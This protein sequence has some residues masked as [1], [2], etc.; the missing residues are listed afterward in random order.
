[1]SVLAC[2]RYKCE[3]VMCDRLSDTFGYICNDCFDELVNTDPNMRI[4]RFM[5]T[6][7]GTFLKECDPVLRFDREFPVQ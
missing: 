4:D 5:Q 7:P 3:N 2:N 1:M 6:K